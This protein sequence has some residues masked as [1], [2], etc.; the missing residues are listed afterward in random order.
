M[1]DTPTNP[2]TQEN[3]AYYLI[4]GIALAAS[5]WV[6]EAYIDTL[7]I[8]NTSFAIRL[9]PSDLNELWMRSFA[10]LLLIGITLRGRG[11]AAHLRLTDLMSLETEQDLQDVLSKTQS[12]APP[13]M[14][15]RCNKIRAQKGEWQD[16]LDFITTQPEIEVKHT[17][18]RKCEIDM[19]SS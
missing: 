10:C 4:G 13:S 18:F 19:I 12:S 15:A 9:L 7:L 16:P 14:C 5:Y 17:M 6:I 2:D 1:T 3:L 8:E 11:V